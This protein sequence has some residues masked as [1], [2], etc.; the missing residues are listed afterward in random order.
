MSAFKNVEGQS[1]AQFR[2]STHPYDALGRSHKICWQ[3][4]DAPLLKA[5]LYG[6]VFREE[7]HHIHKTSQCPSQLQDHRVS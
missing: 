2:V 1:D 3:S 6:S 5:L 4:N 7:E